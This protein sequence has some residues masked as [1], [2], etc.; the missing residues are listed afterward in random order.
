[1]EIDCRTCVVNKECLDQLVS[2]GLNNLEV[3][4]LNFIMDD[5]SP[6]AQEYCEELWD[7]EKK[8]CESSLKTFNICIRNSDREKILFAPDNCT[9]EKE[10]YTYD[11]SYEHYYDEDN[12]EPDYDYYFVDE[13]GYY[14]D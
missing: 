2:N 10:R 1:M 13:L 9:D 8:Y 7:K 12:A 14:D 5:Y 6:D 4:K 11:P 3:L